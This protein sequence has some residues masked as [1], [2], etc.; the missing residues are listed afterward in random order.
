[1]GIDEQNQRENDIIL[2]GQEALIGVVPPN[3]RVV[4][5]TWDEKNIHL[6][7]IYDGA[8]TKEE[9]DDSKQ[10][11]E[12]MAEDFPESKVSASCERVDFP[13][14]FPVRVEK[15]RIWLYA[16]RERRS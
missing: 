14:E 7:F 15:N 5:M 4:E 16:R 6:Y 13:G 12:K 11:A 2:S 9:E 10:V 1:M 3:L 8:F